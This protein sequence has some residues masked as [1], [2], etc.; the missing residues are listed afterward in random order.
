MDL[1]IPYYEDNT[2]ISNSAIGWFLKEGPAYLHSKLSGVAEDETTSAMTRGTAIHMFF[3]QPDEFKN[4]YCIWNSKKPASPQQETFCRE[5]VNT[6]EI[7]PDKAILSAYKKAYRTNGKSDQ[8]LL[9]EASSLAKELKDYIEY[10]RDPVRELITMYDYKQLQKLEQSVNTHKLAKK[11]LYPTQGEVHHE[12][13]INWELHGVPCKSL[14]DSV[15]FDF[16]K[17]ICTLMD[18]KTTVK[19]NHFEDSV[20]QYDYT[21]QLEFYTL[22]L[23]WYLEHEREEDPTVWHFDWY[24]IAMDT[25]GNGRVRVFKFTDDQV[26]LQSVKILDA[27]DDI[28]WHIENNLWDHSRAYYEGDGAETLNL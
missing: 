19:I 23:S 12:F 27:I 8:N 18:I 7:E 1:S 4:T 24:I 21:R 28:K 13:H 6:V 9:L 22:A 20:N 17:K 26:T 16:E 15:H 25:T 5:L 3:L 11:L 10:L 2:R 14:L